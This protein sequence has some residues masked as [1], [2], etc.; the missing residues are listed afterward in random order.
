[1]TTASTTRPLRI[2]LSAYA[3]SSVRGSEAGNSWRLAE[4]LARAGHNVTVL[5]TPRYPG[6]HEIPPELAGHLVIKFV[7]ARAPRLLSRGQVG[8]YADYRAWQHE[9]LRVAR[10]LIRNS[11]FAFDVVHHYSW[12]SLIWGSP[13]IA[14]RLPFVFGP[15]GGG[16]Y[17]PRE[18]RGLYLWRHRLRES[19]RDVLGKSV[20]LNPMA[21]SVVKKATLILSANSDTG[22]VIRRLGGASLLMMPEATPDAWL[23]R[24]ISARPRDNRNV[25]IWVARLLPLKGVLLA[26]DI[27]S[28]LPS[29]FQLVVVGDGPEMQRAQRYVALKGLDERVEFRG[30]VGWETLPELYDAADV[31]L[32]TSIR[33]TTGAQLLE[34]GSCGLPIV[35]INH[36]GIGDYVPQSAGFLAQLGDPELMAAEM[37]SAVVSIC[38]NVELYCSTSSAA[39]AFAESHGAQRSVD[40]FVGVYLRAIDLA[41][42]GP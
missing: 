29:G 13:L 2:L 18:M 23:A 21:R 32:F 9:S 5:T 17:S 7:E 39:R 31:M 12:G 8:V 38:S 36:Q 19:T 37:A 20:R 22:R 28:L 24:P 27:A 35:G 26:I 16:S 4:G 33:D 30:Q 11:P 1:M 15:V 34:A 42:N 10:A 14:L 25:V 6:E 3:L 40:E 41:A